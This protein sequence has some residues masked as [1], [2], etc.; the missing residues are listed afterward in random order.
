MF[1]LFFLRYFLERE[2]YTAFELSLV[3]FF[4]LLLLAFKLDDI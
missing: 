4:P 3:V 2:V 1:T